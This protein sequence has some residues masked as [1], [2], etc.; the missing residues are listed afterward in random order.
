M[1][2]YKEELPMDTLDFRTYD[3]PYETL[4]EAVDNIL[5]LDNQGG[6]PC[7]WFNVDTGKEN[8]KFG[9]DCIGTGHPYIGVEN[10]SKKHYIGTVF[11]GP[12][13][14]HYFINKIED[15]HE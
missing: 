12:Y 14:F 8:S 6:F 15:E 13:V 3:L 4:E 10:V 2:I 9:I 7:M 5:H 11:V 1:L